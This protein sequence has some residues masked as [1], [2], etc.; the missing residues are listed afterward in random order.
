MANLGTLSVD[1]GAR[2][3][4]F[5]Q[6]LADAQAKAS[7]FASGVGKVFA[8]IQISN[9]IDRAAQSVLSLGKQV[10]DLA[11]KAEL[12]TAEF[13]TLT[14][15]VGLG[16]VVFKD[17]ERFA[18]R[19]SFDLQGAADSAAMLLGKGVQQAD[20][21]PTM[22]MLGDLSRGNADKLGFLAKAYTDVQAKGKLMAQEQNQFAETASTC[23]SCW[24]RRPARMLRR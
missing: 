3:S 13:E 4:G 24:A 22:Q 14:G 9:M 8:G 21:I 23:L 1:I 2:T 10:V 6:G 12:M 18:A 19:T 16:A 20:L 11:A 15:N 5:T 7:S 17:L